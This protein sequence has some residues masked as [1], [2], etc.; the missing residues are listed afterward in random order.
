MAEPLSVDALMAQARNE[1][2]LEDFGDPWFLE[3]LNRLVA[4]LNAEGDLS[5]MG[6]FIQ[7]GNISKYLGER[8][9][10]IQ[11]FKDHPEIA[12]EV[13]TVRAEIVGLPR[14]GSTMLHRLLACSEEL[15]STFSWE[16][17]N[18]LP[19]PGESG[20]GPSPRI[21]AAE[22]MTQIYLATMP[23]IAA[24]HPIDPVGYEEDVLLLDRSFIST[25]YATMLKVPSYDAFLLD[26]DQ[27][28]AYR[29]L[30]DWLKILQWQ[31]PARRGKDW[32]LKSPHHL[33]ALPA[34]FAVFPEV[35]VVMTH[36]TPVQ[37]VPSYASMAAA[38]TRPNT[39]ALVPE[40]IGPF[41]VRRFRR[42]LGEVVALR[43]Q[44]PDRF[45]DARY[46]DVQRDPVGEAKRVYAALGLRFGAPEEAAMRD[47]L[48]QNA[49]DR[50]P[51]HHYSAAEFG[52]TAEALET[53]FA[54]Y[55]DA[56]LKN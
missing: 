25:G 18:P 14:T 49:R 6:G 26:F 4:S 5:E 50:H 30:K 10:K 28:P 54:F 20:D 22:Q 35:K 31:A 9:R 37:T 17:L 39:D 51:A 46:E 42:S 41:W 23:E 21:E 3:P 2:G 36:R 13:V 56:F 52:L 32:L 53:D 24:I 15:T 1:S 44:Y 34:L 48:E 8:L 40:A 19:F 7:S 27:T 38:L 47:W 45:I 16:L 33:T 55:I 11:L 43:E 29:E 12:D